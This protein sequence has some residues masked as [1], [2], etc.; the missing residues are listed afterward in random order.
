M[1][2]NLGASEVATAYNDTRA[3]GDL[4]QWGRLADGHQL[5]T[6]GITTNLSGSDNPGNS[7]FIYGMGGPTDWRSPQ[8]D[9]L[10]QGVSGINNPCPPGW[11]IPTQAEWTT[12]YSSWSSQDYNGAFASPLKLTEGGTHNYFNGLVVNVSIEGYYWSS[13]VNYTYADYLSFYNSFAGVES[14]GRANG[15]S[16][17]CIQN[18]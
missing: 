16:V 8:N 11:R 14:T 18:P 10:W 15:D 9:N 12:E 3:Y 1:D 7:N 13:T 6:S 17:R 5:R 4:F 2:R